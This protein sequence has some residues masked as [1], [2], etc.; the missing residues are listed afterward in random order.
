MSRC[1]IGHDYDGLACA[2][3]ARD[4]SREIQRIQA[5][6]S[7]RNGARCISTGTHLSLERAEWLLLGRAFGWQMNDVQIPALC[8]AMLDIKFTDIK[9]DQKGC[10]CGACNRIARDTQGGTAA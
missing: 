10:E 2:T 4:K 1:R 9:N 8:G 7:L 3:C 5:L 6:V